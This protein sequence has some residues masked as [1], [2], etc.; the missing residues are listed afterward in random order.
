MSV[1]VLLRGFFALILSGALAYAIYDRNQRET[2]ETLPPR[3]SR[4]VPYLANYLL[5]LFLLILA[6]ALPFQ[7]DGQTTV[8][9]IFS[10]CFEIFLHISVYYALLL[11]ALP[12]LRRTL[13]ARVCAV[14]WLLPNYLYFTQQSFMQLPGPRWVIRVPAPAVKAAEILWLTGFA[15]VLGWK[16][17]AHLLFRRSVLKDARPVTDPGI[18]ALWREQQAAAG[19]EPKKGGIPLMYA[20]RVRTPLTV[21]FFRKTL[22]VLL[23]ERNYTQEELVLILRHEIIH[24]GREDSFNK[25]FLTFCTAMCWFN[26]LMWMAMRRSADD[27]ELSCDETVLLNADA[28]TRSRYADLLLRTAG[29]ERGFTTCLSAS[30]SALRYRLRNVIKPRKRLEGG[31]AVGLVFFGLIISCGYVALAYPMATGQEGIF[32]S[33]DLLEHRLQS[34]SQVVDGGLQN[35]VC[36]DENALNRYLAELQLYELTGNYSFSSPGRE[37]ILIYQGPRGVFGVHLQDQT[38]GV[39][40]L[41]DEQPEKRNYYLTEPLDW[42]R[43]DEL[44]ILPPE[45]EEDLPLP[46][47]LMLYFNEEANPDGQ[48]MEAEGHV[49]NLA[50]DGQV[51]P[52]G[53]SPPFTG[54]APGI[55]GIQ[56]AEVQLYFS[57]DLYTSSYTVEVENWDRSTS[58]QLFSEDLEDPFLLPLVPYSAHYTL[59]ANFRDGDEVYEMAYRFDVELP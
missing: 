26:P 47:Q 40:P 36:T 20:S 38:V 23:P 22:R 6:V 49:L 42:E 37:M 30:A 27:L 35:Y 14:L 7:Y 3:Q 52:G 58:R 16:I 32:Y 2:M 5:P 1:E 17:V 19:M 48:L 10:M 18:L 55:S 51:Q 33:G 34:V 15:A 44:L 43:L 39:T 41:Y 13:S 59:Y 28:G 11:L 21:G 31:F 57:H 29:D 4:Y 53:E 9:M 50:V 12:L 25:F 56:A 24:I 54:Q 45:T 8:Q 46:P